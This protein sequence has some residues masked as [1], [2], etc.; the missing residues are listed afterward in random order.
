MLREILETSSSC[1]IIKVDKIN[2]S[3][4]FSNFLKATEFIFLLNY[5]HLVRLCSVEK[6][7]HL[8]VFDVSNKYYHLV[9]LVWIAP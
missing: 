7:L 8:T 3:N 9:S 1:M 5:L 2:Q 6:D 4:L